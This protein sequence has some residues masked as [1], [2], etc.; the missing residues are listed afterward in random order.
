MKN[1]EEFRNAVF[2]KAA[3]YKKQRKLKTQKILRLTASFCFCTIFAAAVIFVPVKT[4]VSNQDVHCETPFPTIETEKDC[5]TENS[6]AN[7]TLV[8][9]TETTVET[10]ATTT[11][12]TSAT[13]TI[14][15]SATT[16][17]CTSATTAI[18]TSVTT[19]LADTESTTSLPE[20]S[21]YNGALILCSAYPEQNESIATVLSKQAVRSYDDLSEA[22]AKYFNESFFNSGVIISI[23][24]YTEN[25]Q[26]IPSLAGIQFD[27]NRATVF[28]DLTKSEETESQ[29]TGVKWQVLIPVPDTMV[30]SD[31]HIT[32]EVTTV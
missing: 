13:T 20:S 11:I 15:T 21:F 10:T 25:P 30:S 2:E 16:T 27:E 6:S 22:A 7:E 24:L 19:T 1:H 23:E 8:S 9:T 29:T 12:C 18:C 31:M 4:L 32:V 28:I 3:E 26:T 17:I 5:V 14:C